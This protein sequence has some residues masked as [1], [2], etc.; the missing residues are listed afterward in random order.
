MAQN[1]A[2][3]SGKD[4]GHVVRVREQCGM[5]DGVHTAMDQVQPP[6]RE[7]AHH[8]ACANAGIDQLLTTDY[9][10]LASR[11][12]RDDLVRCAVWTTYAVAKVSHHASVARMVWRD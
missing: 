12:L 2:V 8:R 3:A 9:T 6:R 5:P 4:R 1:G 7:P 11:Q 10:V